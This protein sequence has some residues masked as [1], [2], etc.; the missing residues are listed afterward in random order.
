MITSPVAIFLLVLMIILIGPVLLRRLRIPPLVGLIISGMIIGPYGFG[1]LDRDASFRIFGE[2]GIL[3]I[4]FQAAV[5]IDMF[6]MKQHYRKGLIFGLISFALPMIAG[7]FGSHFIL[8][9]EWD[10]SVLIASMYASHT[11]VSYPVVSKFG[12]QNTIGAVIAVCGTI[13]AVMFALLCLAGVVQAHD[14]GHFDAL[15]IAELLGMMAVYCVAVGYVFPYATR[16]FFRS[17]NDAVTQ[18]IFIL[19]LV[20]VASLLAQIIGLEAILGAFYAGLVLNRMIPSRSPLMKNIRFVG[21]SI[22]IPYFLIGVGMLINVSVLVK[23]WDVVWIALNMT[24]AALS[25]KWLSAWISARIFSLG[26]DE[27][28]L[29]FGL[30]GGKAAA[31][32][33]AV[34]VGISHGMLSEDAMNGAVVMILLCCIVASL[35][36]ESAAKKIRMRLTEADL[37]TD[38]IGSS[39]YA[40]QLVTVSNP[41]TSE[42]LMRTAVFMR[43]RQNPNPLCLLNV[44]TEEEERRRAMGK[45]AIATALAVAD[46]MDVDVNVVERF[47]MSVVSAIRNVAVEQNTTEIVLGMHRKS[48][49]VDSFFGAMTDR[50]LAATNK[51]IVMSR[52]FIPVSTVTNIAVVAPRNAEYETGFHLWVTRVATLAQNVEARLTVI[53]YRETGEYIRSA[54]AED[55]I[56]VETRFEVLDSYDD[57]ILLSGDIGDD[58]L[59]VA[60]CA[61]KGSLS[62]DSDMEAL[63]GFLSKYFSRHNLMVIYPRQFG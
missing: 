35:V 23:G 39:E 17:N 59:I 30:T 45:A 10:T 37:S 11:L 43:N 7:I 34:M 3:Y 58:D 12:L 56:R 26:A 22:F 32:V 21:D 19:A 1:L 9:M 18:Y 33:A 62:Y 27:R 16:R 46:E 55:G 53:S 4:M 29:M 6:H 5:E 49:I 57:F 51:M 63:P 40:R 54:I 52:C 42:G 25:M 8:G 47:D 38:G 61:R 36:T 31:T 2:V 20:F 14:T 41:V 24:V 13:V 15:R 44:R 60:V 50:L 48:T 28:R